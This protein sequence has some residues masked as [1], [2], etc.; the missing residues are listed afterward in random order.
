MKWYL[1]VLQKSFDFNGRARRSEYWHFCLC[2]FLISL[3]MGISGRLVN[4]PL[5]QGLYSLV[6][7]VPTIAVSIRRMHDVGKS[8]WFCIIPF[9]NLIL[10]C[11]N[12]DEGENGYGA[13]PKENNL[14]YN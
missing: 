14:S 1:T 11:R 6:V 13:D 7:L 2:N 10:A 12:G 9:Y 8:G 4:M 5:L 3:A